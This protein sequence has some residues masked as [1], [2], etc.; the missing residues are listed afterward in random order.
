MTRALRILHVLEPPNGG[1]ATHVR[2]LVRGQL[3]AGHVVDAVVCERGPLAGDLRALGAGVAA[4]DLRA[5][6]WAPRP[7]ARAARRLAALMRLRRWDL[8]HSHESKAGVL[9]RPP[10]RALGLAVV[11]SPHT[12]AYATQALRGRGEPRWRLTLEV[13]RALGRISDAVVVP[14]RDLRDRAAADGAAPADR[15]IVVPHGHDPPAATRPHPDLAGLQGDG[16]VV[17]FLSRMTPEKDPLTLVEALG[18]IDGVPFRAAL[19]GDGP[20]AGAVARRV[21]ELGLGGRVGV[22]P[23]AGIGAPAALAG[24]DLY[25]LP[26]LRETFAIGLL[27]AMAAGL[28]AVATRVGA[29]PELARDG[30]TA[31]LVAPGD[32][33]AMAAAIARLLGDGDLRRTMGEAG[34]E[35]AGGY[36]VAAMVQGTERAYAAARERRRRRAAR[37]ASAAS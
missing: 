30:R 19:V 3:R 1:V 10:A 17:G 6:L 26:S 15:L 12:Y 9:A 23:Y 5:E 34:R 4:L 21:A 18:R 36:T 29:V 35:R 22:L 13:E 7:D 37:W 11:H 25:V 14:S 8:V 32:P 24:F 20:L 28:P 2:D 16:P 27:E 31:L 33:A